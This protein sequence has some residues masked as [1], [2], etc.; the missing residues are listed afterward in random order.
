MCNFTYNFPIDID[1]QS[2]VIIILF[3]FMPR[4]EPQLVSCDNPWG[5]LMEKLN[6]KKTKEKIIVFFLLLGKFLIDKT[7]QGKLVNT[8]KRN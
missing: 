6:E 7:L 1:I 2:I 5:F 8:K 4:Q 3:I